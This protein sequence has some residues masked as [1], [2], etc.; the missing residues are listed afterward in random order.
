MAFNPSWPIQ[1]LAHLCSCLSLLI[2]LWHKCY[3]VFLILPFKVVSVG[4]ALSFP[5]HVCFRSRKDGLCRPIENT[6]GCRAWKS[7][8]VDLTS[9]LGW[10]N[11]CRTLKG[12]T[13]N[14]GESSSSCVQSVC[15]RLYV[16][17]H[18]STGRK[19]TFIWIHNAFSYGALAYNDSE[20]GQ[21]KGGLKTCSTVQKYGVSEM[22]VC[23]FKKCIKLIKNA[24]KA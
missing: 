15:T 1:C 22:C 20:W 7:K 23:F 6:L 14:M 11:L 9:L 5:V 24:V 3:N 8:I 4:M 13:V 10:S 21:F 19:E 16:C 17:C 2:T 18:S 12:F